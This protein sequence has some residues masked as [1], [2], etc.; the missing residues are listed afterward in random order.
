MQIRFLSVMILVSSLCPYLSWGKTNHTFLFQAEWLVLNKFLSTPS[1]AMHPLIIVPI[2]SQILI[3]IFGV[4]SP[5][6]AL[7]YLGILGLYLLI[8]FILLAGFLS[9]NIWIVLSCAPFIIC[10]TLFILLAKKK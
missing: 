10:S 1:A 6:I 8:A 7:V 5:K 2:L 3:V 4:I 9:G